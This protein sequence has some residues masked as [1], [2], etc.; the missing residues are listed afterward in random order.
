MVSPR[1][2]HTMLTSRS[3]DNFLSCRADMYQSQILENFMSGS[4]AGEREREDSLNKVLSEKY[5]Q[6]VKEISALE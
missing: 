2:V 6:N 3:G 5:E 1:N 4:K